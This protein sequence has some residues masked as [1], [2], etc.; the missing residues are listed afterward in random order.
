[1]RYCP[2]LKLPWIIFCLHYHKDSLQPSYITNYFCQIFI[3]NDSIKPASVIMIQIISGLRIF[4]LSVF[5]LII[6][7]FTFFAIESNP[8][9]SN[10]YQNKKWTAPKEADKVENPLKGNTAATKQG[11][12]LFDTQC[13]SCHG[14]EGKGN[15]PAGLQLK[16][17]PQ[18]LSS[19]EV[20]KQTDGAIF[21]KITN[22]RPPMA[23]YKYTF[24]DK[25]RW[26]LVN[27]VRE[28]RKK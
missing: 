23:S 1:M 27:Y 22:G 5:F 18:N 8:A 19:E 10:N 24:T 4:L 7:G 6:S 14:P 13:A 2:T 25:Q 12:I 17:R 15:G 3:F 16:P 11:K 20:Q 9:Q 21:W 28:L 26:E